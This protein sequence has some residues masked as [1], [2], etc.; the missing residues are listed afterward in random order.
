MSA[1]GRKWAEEVL[2]LA[3]DGKSSVEKNGVR[4][5]PMRVL[6]MGLSRTGTTCQYLDNLFS[7]GKN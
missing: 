6:I 3:N 1:K 2:A 5:K 7:D 4:T